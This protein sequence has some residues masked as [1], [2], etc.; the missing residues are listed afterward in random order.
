MAKNKKE[1]ESK[2]LGKQV[3]IIHLEGE[4][5]RYDGKTGTVS[6]VDDMGDLHG[7]WGGLAII[8]DCDKF[9]VLD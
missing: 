7:T 3:K 6:Y 4:D 2:Y 8:V 9:E 5:G 1:I